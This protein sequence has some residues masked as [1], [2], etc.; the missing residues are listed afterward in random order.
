MRIISPLSNFFISLNTVVE[1]LKDNLSEF[2]PTRFP[3]T[4]KRQKVLAR[5]LRYR[6]LCVDTALKAA[7]RGKTDH[8]NRLTHLKNVTG[9]KI[10][11]IKKFINLDIWKR[12]S[13]RLVDEQLTDHRN[14]NLKFAKRINKRSSNSV[15]FPCNVTYRFSHLKSAMLTTA[16]SF[17]LFAA[18]NCIS[19]QHIWR[20]LSK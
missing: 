4:A 2:P 14:W 3:S 16:K 20:L 8:V 5:N 10:S 17:S 13:K 11:M 15:C 19:H 7:I 1:R 9:H 18:F 6:G 12:H